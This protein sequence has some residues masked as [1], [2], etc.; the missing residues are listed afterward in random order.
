MSESVASKE[1]H[2]ML[3]LER[4]VGESKSA[5]EPAWLTDLRGAA[6][7][8]FSQTPQGFGK[9]SRLRLQWQDMPLVPPATTSSDTGWGLAAGALAAAGKYAGPLREALSAEADLAK[10]LLA[11]VTPWDDLVL[12]GWRHGLFLRLGGGAGSGVPYLVRGGEPGVA[13]EPIVVDVPTGV[14]ASLFLHFR[15]TQEPSLRLS[16]LRVR[17]GDSARLK[18]FHLH[19]G[20]AAHHHLSAAVSVGQDAAVESFGAWMGG[21]WSVFRSAADLARPG[22]SWRESHLVAATG[23]DHVDLDTQVI[24]SEHHTR[25]DVQVKTVAA[26]FARAVFTGNIR[27]E[28]QARAGE[29]YLSDHTLLLSPQARA[30]SVPGL[31]IRAQD[32][33]AAH[34]ASAGQLDEEQ[35]FYLMSRGLDPARARHLIVVGFLESL[36]DRAPFPF[37]PQILDPALESKVVA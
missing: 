20:S 32:V 14:E 5:G 7:M 33:K 30:D 36:F 4:V 34:A 12:A 6:L 23:R 28:A 11:P 2:P 17:V 29:A 1:P 31:E 22:A 16:A 35:M 18:L 27:M 13:L 9:Y 37:V 15:G 19:E 25:S 24:H 3:T 8:R 26:N 21:S 10:T